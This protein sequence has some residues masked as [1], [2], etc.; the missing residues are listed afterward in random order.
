MIRL[1]EET[2]RTLSAG[3]SGDTF[4]PDWD[5]GKRPAHVPGLYV[6]VRESGASYTIQWRQLQGQKQRRLVL[7]KVGAISLAEARRSARQKFEEIAQGRDPIAERAR[8]RTERTFGEAAEEYLQARVGT[9]KPRSIAECRK[10][11]MRYF[12]NLHPLTVAAVNRA[13]IATELRTIIRE[14]GPIA[15]DRARGTLSAFYGWC[16]AHGLTEANPVIGTIKSGMEKARDRVLTDG[17]LVKVW[18]SAPDA[19]YGRIVKLLILTGQ[20]RDEIAGM[21]REELGED[22]LTLPKERTKNGRP[23]DVPLSDQ[24]LAV[25]AEHPERADSDFVFGRGEAGFSGYS[26]SKE[27]LDEASGVTDWVIHDL[28]RTVAT[29][30]ANI[31]VQP[32]IIEAILN[33]VSGHKAGVAGIYNRSTYAAEKR[34]ALALWGSHVMTLLAKAANVT[35]LRRA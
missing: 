33:H 16:I 22:V 23:H 3:E 32:H 14:H 17:E 27:R 24:A 30:M 29:G 12:K 2:V 9:M 19:D 1:T 20:R 13:L 15:S 26:R 21:R 7:G 11:L 5:S 28:R 10:H 8:S 35:V 6:R 31:G 4:Y 25:L 34:A 18:N